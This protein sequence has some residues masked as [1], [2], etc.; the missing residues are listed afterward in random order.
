MRVAKRALV[1]GLG[2]ALALS[3]C[4]AKTNRLT[5][6][7]GAS[8]SVHATSSARASGEPSPHGSPATGTSGASSPSGTHQAAAYKD[9]GNVGDMAR[10]YLRSSPARRLVV[11]VDYVKNERPDQGALDHLAAILRRECDKPGGVS[12]DLGD[13]IPAQHDAYTI[14]Q[15]AAIERRYRSTHSDGDTASMWL[16]Y[17]NGSFAEGEGALGI[18][19][20]G[21][22]AAIFRDQIDSATTAIVTAG[23]IERSVVTHEAGHLLG[24][25][26]FGYRSR[27]DHEDAEHPHHS[28]SKDS[29]MYYAVEDVSITALLSGGPPD[30]FDQYDRADLASLRDT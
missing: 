25:T 13:Q 22:A 1:A 11:E 30:D 12:V 5:W 15:I 9:E 27:Y 8:P 24:M 4:S 10:A 17:L 18:A 28:N 20:E 14:D 6:G 26:N 21:S 29:V 19:Y 2:A 23:A 7:D 3:A 16:L